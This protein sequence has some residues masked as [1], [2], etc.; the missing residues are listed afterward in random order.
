MLDGLYWYCHI[1]GRAPEGKALF[2]LAETGLAPRA[3]E[4]PSLTWGRLLPRYEDSAE[5]LRTRSETA[6]RIA[7]HYEDEGEIAFATWR[8]GNYFAWLEQYAEAI[9]YFERSLA[10]YQALGD[11]FYV[12]RVLFNLGFSRGLALVTRRICARCRKGS[13]SAARMA[14]SHCWVTSCCT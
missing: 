3:G 2:R 7:C 8:A 10:Q 13:P 14:T 5:D 6:L 12:G 1:R 11:A 9:P 4:A